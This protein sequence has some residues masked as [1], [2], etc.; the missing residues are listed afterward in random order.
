MSPVVS[1]FARAL[2][3]NLVQHACKA[4]RAMVG[5]ASGPASTAGVCGFPRARTRA[6][7]VPYASTTSRFVFVGVRR[8]RLERRAVEGSDIGAT[9]TAG[10]VAGS[11]VK[12]GD[13]VFDKRTYS[14]WSC[15]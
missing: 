15:T 11:D 7:H 13:S 6:H 2:Q 10:R 5:R 9:T 12:Q 8:G 14:P 4:A 3:T 1:F